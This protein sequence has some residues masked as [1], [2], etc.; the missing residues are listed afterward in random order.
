MDQIRFDFFNSQA[1]TALSRN[2]PTPGDPPDAFSQVLDQELKTADDTAQ[3]GQETPQPRSSP[4]RS[5]DDTDRPDPS[6]QRVAERRRDDANAASATTTAKPK[7]A[8]KPAPSTAKPAGDKTETTHAGDTGKAKPN[9]GNDDGDEKGTTAAHPASSD[10]GTP[11]AKTDDKPAA[12]TDQNGQQQGQPQQQGDGEENPS[13]PAKADADAT[14]DAALAGL[15]LPLP[16]QII[17]TAAN[18][19]GSAVIGGGTT[20][21]LR[22]AL[23]VAANLNAGALNIAGTSNVQ[24]QR[25]IAGLKFGAILPDPTPN[26][27]KA[28]TG[29]T[30]GATSGT[31]RSDPAADVPD[32][33]KT[34]PALPAPKPQ[35]NAPPGTSAKTKSTANPS[36]P[37]AAAYAGQS[38][39]VATQPV[40][41]SIVQPWAAAGVAAGISADTLAGPA[42]SGDADLSGWPP[43]LDADAVGAV[44]PGASARTAAFLAQLK[45]NV[46]VPPAHEQVAIQIQKA[47][48]NGS[49][50]LTVSLEP[51]ELGRVEVKLDVDK[52]K[53]VTASI[54][55]DRPATLDLLQR[56]AKTL[57]RALQDAGLQT[58][59]G[60][61]SFSLRNG[62]GQDGGGNGANG[63]AGAG[64][65]GGDT[66]AQASDAANQ[67]A[68]AGVIA[69]ADGYVDLET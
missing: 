41:P 17:S 16:L 8:Q 29:A 68:R 58:N 2:A 34:I 48:Q 56:D 20:P 57:E 31:D 66:G 69:T 37:V 38:G 21:A 30:T 13:A 24:A 35:A 51:A 11:T 52:D 40:A 64:I 39:A 23:L 32:P 59:D 42:V 14:A 22:A 5:A 1:V 36:S 62:T 18:P 55:V 49:N 4:R 65:R 6:P 3:Q 45:Q 63:Q 60:S 50:R 25:S 61:L 47:M 7:A 19:K 44:S 53:K 15:I 43:Y 9:Q 12:N 33:S 54:I 27:A 46:Q 10:T 26:Q 28:G 67:P